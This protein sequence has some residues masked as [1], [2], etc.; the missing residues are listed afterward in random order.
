MSNNAWTAEQDE[1]LRALWTRGLSASQIG[2]RFGR[3]KN[4]VIGRINRLGGIERRKSPIKT[5][6]PAQFPYAQVETLLRNGWPVMR[7]AAQFRVDHN[8]VRL[9]RDSIG[10]APYTVQ[11]REA[12]KKVMRAVV[13]V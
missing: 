9:I 1:E 10:V 3:S 8:R 11:K 2:A 5:F 12:E 13:A 6:S 4:A 7:V